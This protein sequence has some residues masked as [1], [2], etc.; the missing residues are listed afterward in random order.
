MIVKEIFL[1]EIILLG[2]YDNCP[3]PLDGNYAGLPSAPDPLTAESCDVM[4]D[5]PKN[6]IDTDEISRCYKHQFGEK[7]GSGSDPYAGMDFIIRC[8]HQFADCGGTTGDGEFGLAE[9]RCWNTDPGNPD[10]DGD[11]TPDEADVAGLNQQQFTW[12]YREGDRVGV[13]VEGTSMI[14]INEGGRDLEAEDYWES[15]QGIFNTYQ[16]AADAAGQ[17]LPPELETDGTFES[18]GTIDSTTD[19]TS[20][21]T[22]NT[23]PVTGDSTTTTDSTSTTTGTTTETGTS[24]ETTE[25]EPLNDYERSME[26]IVQRTDQSR[27]DEDNGALNAYFKIM[28]ATPDFCSSGGQ[29]D[30]DMDFIG[31]DACDDSAD[32]GFPYLEAL[33]VNEKGRDILDPELEVVP[34]NPQYADYDGARP[35]DSDI[36]TVSAGINND[37]VDEDFLFYDWRIYRCT[38]N[39]FYSCNQEANNITNLFEFESLR[40][41]LGVKKIRVMPTS[42][43]FSGGDRVWVKVITLVSRHEDLVGNDDI[44]RDFDQTYF[45]IG[46]IGEVMVPIYRNR[47]SINLYR[48]EFSGS[49][50]TR[51][52]QIC[53]TGLYQDVCPVYPYEV[54]FAEAS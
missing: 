44:V 38:E 12:T 37:F 17:L 1:M 49:Q 51:G 45:P 46:A 29:N 30:L 33:S 18:T 25:I 5:W 6:I 23:D 28:W 10:T 22:G 40:N 39:D 54:I 43:V 34:E 36:I 42:S 8:Q 20:S 31:G 48:G 9:E 4:Y 41:G 32:I 15:D 3:P 53:Q 13:I 26:S 11:G 27:A 14:P 7:F 24:E 35:E 19:S 16:E 50:W 52:E 47:I 2:R 21:T